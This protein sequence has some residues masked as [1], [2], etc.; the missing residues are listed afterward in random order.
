MSLEELL[1][2]YIEELKVV[3]KTHANAGNVDEAM[4]IHHKLCALEN[5]RLKN[6]LMIAKQLEE[7]YKREGN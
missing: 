4:V 2:K 7:L 1:D 5:L 6:T 3:F